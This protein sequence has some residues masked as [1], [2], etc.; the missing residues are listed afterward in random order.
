M[1]RLHAHGLLHKS[2]LSPNARAFVYYKSLAKCAL[3]I[4]IQAFNH[5]SSFKVRPFRLPS[6]E[7]LA[8]LLRS[9]QGGG[10]GATIDLSNC[11]WSVHLP[12]AMAGAARVAAAGTTCALVRV[13]FGWHQVPGLVQ[14]FIGAVL[15]ELPGMQVIIVQYLDDILFVG[16]DGLL[17]T[18]VA[19][20]TA[21]HLTRKGFLV[22]PKSVPQCHSIPYVDGEATQPG[23]RG[24]VSAP[25]ARRASFWTRAPLVAF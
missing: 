8:G 18:H 10:G 21:V 12:P 15:S 7:G 22:S 17:T 3:I 24:N 9:V 23:Y 13:P 1:R 20:D 6:L 4:D 19:R 25:G 14:H 5:A 2:P 16:R 11:Y